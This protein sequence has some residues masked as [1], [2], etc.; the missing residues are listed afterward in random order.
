MSYVAWSLY[1]CVW[2]TGKLCQN[3]WTELYA[4]WGR[5]H[6]G[7]RNHVLD[8]AQ[9]PPREG[10]LVRG[11]VPAIVTYLRISAC[12]SSAAAGEC[13]CSRTRRTNAF[14][15]ARCHVT[16]R[17]CGLLLNDFGHLFSVVKSSR[18]YSL[19]GVR[20]F[21]WHWAT[22]SCCCCLSHTFTAAEFTETLGKVSSLTRFLTYLY[23]MYTV[24]KYYLAGTGF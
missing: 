8:E 24:N 22:I 10:E 2:H 9:N 14:A 23:K 18:Y 16:R 1:L 3:G 20:L 12:C 15:V 6:V 4:V 7:P 11:H 13:A 21:Q 19:T 5:T 17:R